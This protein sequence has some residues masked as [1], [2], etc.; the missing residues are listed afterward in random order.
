MITDMIEKTILLG[1]EYM[2][3]PMEGIALVLLIVIIAFFFI[4]W[5]KKK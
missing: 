3:I 2:N 5:R 1:K 4:F